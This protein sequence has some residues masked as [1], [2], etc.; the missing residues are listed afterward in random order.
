MVYTRQSAAVLLISLAL[1]ACGDGSDSTPGIEVKVNRDN[2]K[3]TCTLELKLIAYRNL[4]VGEACL[5]ES[6]V[7][8]AGQGQGTL[9]DLSLDENESIVLGVLAYC[10]GAAFCPVCWDS[11]QIQ[12]KNGTEHQLSLKPAGG[13]LIGDPM[14]LLVGTA[15]E[16]CTP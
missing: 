4:D 11:K 10:V 5:I 3:Q 2:C 15:P 9:D 13:C 6:R 14:L 16:M 8:S 7:A 1:T 12:V